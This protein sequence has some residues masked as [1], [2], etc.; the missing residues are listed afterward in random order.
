M[1]R[2]LYRILKWVQ[3]R[4]HTV[5]QYAVDEIGDTGDMLKKEEVGKR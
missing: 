4:V 1:N 5:V 3:R 2:H